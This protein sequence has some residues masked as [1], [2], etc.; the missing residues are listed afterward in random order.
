MNRIQAGHMLPHHP[1]A[2]KPKRT[3]SP[4]QH[5]ASFQQL[6][7]NQMLTFSNHAAERLKQRGIQLK[8]EQ[9]LKLTT[10]LDKAEAKGSKDTLLLFQDMAFIVNVKNRTVVTAMDK[11][12]MKDNVFT[13]IDSTVII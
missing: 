6:L 7:N 1:V 3:N 9:L 11:A 13:Q 12:G 10:A 4:A 8:P 2:G 5:P